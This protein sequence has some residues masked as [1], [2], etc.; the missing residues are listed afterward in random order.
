VRAN[1]PA[2]DV[3][4]TDSTGAGDAFNA[5]LLASW[6]TDGDPVAALSAGVAAGTAAAAAVG[7]RPTSA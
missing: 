1:V 4:E 2:P 6:L 5:G 7:A 3:H